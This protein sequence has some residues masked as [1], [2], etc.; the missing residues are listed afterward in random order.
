MAKVPK[1]NVSQTMA[2]VIGTMIPAFAFL[3]YWQGVGFLVNAGIAVIS[4]IVFETLTKAEGRMGLSTAPNAPLRTIIDWPTVLTALLFAAGVPALASPWVLI[5]GMFFAIVIAKN[6]FGGL[7][8]NIFNPAM[9]GYAVV[10]IAFP[11]EMVVWPSWA[12]DSVS[13]AT[14]L[15]HANNTPVGSPLLPY[16]MLNALWLLGGLILLAKKIIRWQIPV[17]TLCGLIVCSLFFPDPWMQWGLGATLVGAFYIATDPVTAPG[18]P[19]MRFIFGFLIGTLIILLRQYSSYPD[20]VA[21]AVLLANMVTPL[22]D[23]FSIR[24]SS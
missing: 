7:G 19:R 8:H 21:F 22:M 14:P 10:L 17:G 9:V 16:F 23:Q 4:G 20:G 15:D 11:S 1:L 18:T 5:V 3:T 13:S 12:L 2:W 24:K 6:L